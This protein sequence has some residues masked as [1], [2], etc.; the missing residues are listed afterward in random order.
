VQPF[1]QPR[2]PRKTRAIICGC[3]HVKHFAHGLCARHYQRW[4]ILKRGDP[5]L[6]PSRS[7]TAWFAGAASRSLPVLPI[8][9]APADMLLPVGDFEWVERICDL[10]T[11]RQPFIARAPTQRFCDCNCFAASPR[12]DAPRPLSVDRRRG[13]EAGRSARWR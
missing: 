12:R 4:I 13:L 6:T 9:A 5:T 1:C 7:I 10:E 8:A 3:Q 2:L 11:C